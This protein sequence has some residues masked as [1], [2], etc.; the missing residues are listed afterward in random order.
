M[1]KLEQFQLKQKLDAE[2]HQYN[3]EGLKAIQSALFISW[4]RDGKP[5]EP[6]DNEIFKH[7]YIYLSGL[8]QRIWDIVMLRKV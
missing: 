4:V 2:T 6:K 8:I 3:M 7:D 1:N 5:K